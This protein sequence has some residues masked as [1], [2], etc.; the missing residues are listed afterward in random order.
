MRQRLAV[1]A[2]PRGAPGDPNQEMISRARLHRRPER[3]QLLEVALPHDAPDGGRALEQAVEPRVARVS[4]VFR[5]I[6]N[7]DFAAS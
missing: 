1:V 2:S 7:T 4:C 3:L 5:A 6:V